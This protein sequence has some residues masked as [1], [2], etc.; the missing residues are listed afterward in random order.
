[1]VLDR[2]S[3]PAASPGGEL[4]NPASF[5]SVI[6]AFSAARPSLPT[7][8]DQRGNHVRPEITLVHADIPVAGPAQIKEFSNRLLGLFTFPHPKYFIRILYFF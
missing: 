8:T 6:S 5:R 7:R 4:I 2:I 3:E 1:M